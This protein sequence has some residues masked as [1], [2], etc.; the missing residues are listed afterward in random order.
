MRIKLKK[1]IRQFDKILFK[2]IIN[3]TISGMNKFSVRKIILP[4]NFIDLT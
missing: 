4:Y 3:K 1:V 2:N